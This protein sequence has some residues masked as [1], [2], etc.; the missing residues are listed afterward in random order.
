MTVAYQSICG[1]RPMEVAYNVIGI[2]PDPAGLKSAS[3]S[4]QTP[5]GKVSSSF[6]NT[7]NIF[8]LN[9]DIPSA[10]EGVIGTPKE[11]VR[12]VKI[13]G[14]TVWKDG[15]PVKNKIARWSKH[16]TS[17]LHLSFDVPGGTYKLIA[18]K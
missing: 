3:A 6:E 1:I 18:V 2:L 16:Q 10:Y 13:N 7:N 17:D 12:E 5:A 4:V 11:G 9:A 15:K 14:V 8:V